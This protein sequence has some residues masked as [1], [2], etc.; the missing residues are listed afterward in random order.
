MKLTR[1]TSHRLFHLAWLLAGIALPTAVA[2]AAP[3]PETRSALFA[4]G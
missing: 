3:A 4:A 1:M 2:G